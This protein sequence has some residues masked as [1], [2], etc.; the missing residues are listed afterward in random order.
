MAAV[1]LPSSEVERTLRLP[2]FT[3]CDIA[4]LNAPDQTVVSGPDLAMEPL[5]TQFKASNVRVTKLRTPYAFHSKQMD[6]ILS[7]YRQMAE[8]IPFKKPSIPVGSTVLG[9]V[10]Q[11]EGTLSPQY[12]CRQTR[13]P[14][15]FQD[16]LYKLEGLLEDGQNPMWIEIGPGPAC[17]PMMASAIRARPTNLV[18]ALDP[19]KPNWLTISNLITK[20]YCSNGHVQWD[21][22][23]KEYLDALSLLQLPSYPFDLKKYWIQYDG[24]WVIRKNK[25]ASVQLQAAQ[26][27]APTLES[28]TLHRLDNDSVDKRTW[29][30]IF[31]SDLSTG[32]SGSMIGRYQ[33]DGQSACPSSIYVD[34]AMAAA[35][36]HCKTSDRSSRSLAMEVST[37]EICSDLDLVVAQSIK[38]VATQRPSDTNIVEI[39]ITFWDHGDIIELMRCKVVIGD[40]EDWA[41]D[42]NRNAYLYQSRM[43]LLNLFLTN[44]QT[45]R[46]SQSEVYQKFSSFT[47]YK[48]T[49]QGIREVLLNLGCLEAA[50]KIC[51]PPNKG[52]HVCDPRWLDT[53]YKCQAWLSTAAMA[54]R[55]KPITLAM[56]GTGCT[57]CSLWSLTPSTEFTCGCKLSG[58]Q[59]PWSVTCTSSTKQVAQLL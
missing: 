28:S 38:L 36:Y 34:M 19:K 29:K 17:L 5:I 39:S 46:L 7:E 30:L 54:A 11:E 18:C 50:A 24:D 16:A 32:D 27:T 9:E 13:E 14:V 44:G 22:Y 4:C 49:F 35:S 40:G 8:C 59:V 6:V 33:V 10:V 48:P 53:L 41:N 57:F 52:T 20:Y 51:L 42:A 43:D 15:R 37:L 26:A 25:K 12:L 47:D 31:T 56:A 21:E 45:S 58:R 2:R 23:H 55:P 1:S 3:G